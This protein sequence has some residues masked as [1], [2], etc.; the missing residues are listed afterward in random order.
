MLVSEVK[1]LRPSLIILIPSSVIVEHLLTNNENI[2]V[3][4][5]IYCAKARVKFVTEVRCLK[6]LLIH[7][8]PVSVIDLH[9]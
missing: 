9:L 5:R 1:R 2:H 7:F 6:E 3:I 8:I 4:R